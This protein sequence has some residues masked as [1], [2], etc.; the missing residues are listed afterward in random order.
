MS[1]QC[2]SRTP[3]EAASE[4]RLNSRRMKPLVTSFCTGGFAIV[5][6]VLSPDANGLLMDHHQEWPA[7]VCIVQTTKL[8]HYVLQVRSVCHP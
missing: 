6:S 3:Y 5:G 7:K 1:E 4:M 2:S 8:S